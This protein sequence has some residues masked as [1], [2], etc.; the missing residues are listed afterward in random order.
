MA[1]PESI[2]T[3]TPGVKDSK[4]SN[5][6]SLSTAVARMRAQK[7]MV[8]IRRLL[9]HALVG[10]SRLDPE[11]RYVSVNQAYAGMIGYDP[12]AMIGMHWQKTV[13]PDELDKGVAA[14][15]AMLEEGKVEYETRGLR[16]DGSVFYK[17]IVIVTAYDEEGRLTGHYCCMRNVAERKEAGAA[18]Q[19]AYDK[20]ESR[21]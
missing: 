20:L 18:P 13:H 6:A 10:I 21:V 17:H 19:R 3:K 14:Y 8:E 5:R 7:E 15:Q 2:D 1:T 9:E 16:K 11:G 4:G 12:N